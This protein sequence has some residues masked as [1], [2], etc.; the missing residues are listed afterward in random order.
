MA[1]VIEVLLCRCQGSGRAELDWERLSKNLE[2]NKRIAKVYA[3]ERL[4]LPEGREKALSLL[5]GGEQKTVVLAACLED[6]IPRLLANALLHKEHHVSA[7][8]V[9][10]HTAPVAPTEDEKGSRSLAEASKHTFTQT[11]N[12][13]YRTSIR[14]A[15][16]RDMVLWSYPGSRPT[17]AAADIVKMVVNRARQSAPSPV[18]SAHCA[19]I[20]RLRCDQC[21]RCLEECPVKAYSLDQEGYPQANPDICR[22]CGICVGSCPLQVI[23]LPNFK[24]DDLSREIVSMK[25][26]GS[27]APTVVAFACESLTYPAL[28]SKISEGFL[29]P[30]NLRVVKVP[31][32]GAVNSALITDALSSGIDGVMLLGCQYGPCKERRGD[33]AVAQRL[34]NLKETLQRMMF[35]TERVAYVGWPEAVS[36]GML[37]DESKCNGCLICQNVCQFNAVTVLERDCCGTLKWIS[38]RDPLACRGCGLCS[39]ACPSGACQLQDGGDVSMVQALDNVCTGTAKTSRRDFV[40][41]CACEGRLERE[42]DYPLL[43][44]RLREQDIRTVIVA[45]RLCTAAGWRELKEKLGEKDSGCSVIGACRAFNGRMKKFQKDVRVDGVVW[46][47]LDLWNYCGDKRIDPTGKAKAAI[48]EALAVLGFCQGIERTEVEVQDKRM[49]TMSKTI[50]EILSDY[51]HML[52]ELGPNPFREE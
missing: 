38:A 50:A 46:R 45:D 36:T 47:H 3:V 15:G 51:E 40:V 30:A 11:S 9:D 44:E 24:L 49:E 20:N 42:L 10:H 27:E 43:K 8:Q 25:G 7:F 37:V 23:S 2:K 5:Q 6:N 34:Q 33:Q 31:C 28:Q 39:V 1:D 4:C 19:T 14:V 29:L 48:N 13:E 22:M 32:L 17:E 52:Q 26:D 16:I 12:I 41:L 35:E 21:K 18:H